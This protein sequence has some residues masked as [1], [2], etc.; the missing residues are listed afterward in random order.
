MRTP[1]RPNI[2]SFDLTF[3]KEN[4]A[5]GNTFVALKAAL[6]SYKA[7]LNYNLARILSE[8]SSSQATN[9]RDLFGDLTSNVAARAKINR[10]GNHSGEA[11]QFRGKVSNY[12]RS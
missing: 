11:K 7:G 2:F 8:H 10:L 5:N 3:G 9:Q 6:R 1:S 4:D 12:Q